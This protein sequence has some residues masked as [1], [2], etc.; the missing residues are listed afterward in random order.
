MCAVRRE[1][2]ARW[3]VRAV[4]ESHDGSREA[5]V[6]VEALTAF[7]LGVT[8]GHDDD[9]ATDAPP[10]SSMAAAPTHV[11]LA[12]ALACEMLLAVDGGASKYLPRAFAQVA[13]P[14]ALKEGGAA[15]RAPLLVLRGL[16][17]ELSEELEEDKTALKHV[18]RIAERLDALL[19]V[20]AAA[21]EEPE[22]GEE[23]DGDHD[24]EHLTAATVLEA[25]RSA[26][27]AEKARAAARRA[28]ADDAAETA[29]PLADADVRR[30]SAEDAGK[31]AIAPARRKLA[32][33]RAAGLTPSKGSAAYA[34]DENVAGVNVGA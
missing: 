17:G 10:P 5:S 7:V 22:A 11:Q 15:A 18:A 28:A 27:K 4:F 23:T 8:D 24:G 3:Q 31:A 19:G 32:K 20:A 34:A 13:L 12:S 2:A 9:G 6:S 26:K 30:A 25:H 29:V 33:A 1:M 16:L 21:P 14:S